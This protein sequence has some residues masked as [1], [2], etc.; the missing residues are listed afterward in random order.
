VP[1]K[2]GAMNLWL[3]PSINDQIILQSCVSALAEK[4]YKILD[5]RV[6]SYRLNTEPDQLRLTPSQIHSWRKF[7]DDTGLMLRQHSH[8][9]QFDLESSFRNVDAS[10]FLGFLEEFAPGS[11]EI[12]LLRALWASYAGPGIPP[13]NDSLFFLGN[14]Y[15][16]LVDQCVKKHT[17]SFIR[18]VDD[19]R[20]FGDSENQLESILEQIGRQLGALGFKINP[21][22]TRLGSSQDYLDAIMPDQFAAPGPIAGS[23]YPS[24][25]MFDDVL[26]PADLVRQIDRILD[27]P[28]KYLNDGVG[29]LI[30]GA[31]RRMRADD[32]MARSRGNLSSS[33]KEFGELVSADE[34]RCGKLLDL[35]HDYAAAPNEAWRAVWLIFLLEDVNPRNQEM[36]ARR[37]RALADLQGASSV[38]VVKLWAKSVGGATPSPPGENMDSL[39]Y[40][41]AGFQLYGG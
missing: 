31:I 36:S 12:R 41:E 4:V 29:R 10:A 33:L 22:K 38:P 27:G 14:A 20:I 17:N 16:N 5:H 35:L 7:Q 26:K 24:A 23:D 40:L 30:L 37:S 32:K 8:L 11:V 6:Y 18:F 1:K 21:I 2:S 34:R 25:I 19:Y 13:I 3:V 9:L 39:G 28:E 15:F